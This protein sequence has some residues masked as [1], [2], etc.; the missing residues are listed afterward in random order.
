[1]N[2]LKS[3]SLFTLSFFTFLQP[4]FSA[5]DQKAL[6]TT[7]N[8]LNQVSPDASGN[9]EI[10]AE[11]EIECRDNENVCIARGNARAKK[12]NIEV[13]GQEL[14]LYFE[15]EGKERK[16]KALEAIGGA[17]LK[18]PSSL[19]EADKLYYTVDNETLEATGENLFLQTPKYR[20]TAKEKLTYSNLTHKGEAFKDAIFIEQDRKIFADMLIAYF[21]PDST[22]SKKGE[23]GPLGKGGEKS[24]KLKKV[25]AKGNV[26]I[27]KPPKRAKCDEAW[28]DAETENAYLTGNVK[29]FEG[30]SFAKGNKGLFNVKSGQAKLLGTPKKGVKM[31]VKPKNAKFKQKHKNRH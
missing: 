13:F 10:D 19:V 5:S 8:S 24:L 28:Y 14:R 7:K 23:G 1:M 17:V 9:I 18:T 21:I 22:Q 15:K 20:L 11:Q 29:L 4:T 31:L 27:D 30:E 12:G 2:K 26:I 25:E 16:I 6:P 3:Y